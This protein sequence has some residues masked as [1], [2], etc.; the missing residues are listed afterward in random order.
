MSLEVNVADTIDDVPTCRAGINELARV[1]ASTIS[2]TR[3]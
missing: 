1:S 2:A 3:S